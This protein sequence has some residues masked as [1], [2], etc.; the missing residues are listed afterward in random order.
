M[1][2]PNAGEFDFSDEGG[3]DLDPEHT[4]IVQV[5]GDPKAGK[6]S[7]TIR[8]GRKVLFLSFDRETKPIADKQMFKD[9]GIEVS[10]KAGDRYL[11]RFI[12]GELRMV[13][14][15]EIPKAA[16]KNMKYLKGLLQPERYTDETKPDLV[17]FD[18]TEDL[19][20]LADWAAR[21]E[22]SQGK[23]PNGFRVDEDIPEHNGSFWEL[24]NN[25]MRELMELAEA[26]TTRMVVFTTG[27]GYKEEKNHKPEIIKPNWTKR[28]DVVLTA[29]PNRPKTRTAGKAT[30]ADFFF[31]VYSCKNDEDLVPT[32]ETYNM[33]T[34]DLRDKLDTYFGKDTP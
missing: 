30:E 15:R 31:S 9:L 18:S 7:G 32:G 5:A 13:P 20:R 11:R 3:S 22:F 21:G 4:L 19:K 8:L 6:T 23:H 34:H 25:H 33:R 24:R 2:L 26:L 1:P 27:F 17:A 10:V 12:D 14:Q 29:L 16:S 28:A